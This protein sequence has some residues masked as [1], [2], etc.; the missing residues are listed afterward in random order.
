M[1][2]CGRGPCATSLLTASRSRSDAALAMA[3]RS[4][5]A[6][7]LA[8]PTA[9]GVREA[10][11]TAQQAAGP[12]HERTKR[13]YASLVTVMLSNEMLRTVFDGK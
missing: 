1:R 8:S 12:R 2:A 5:Q 7:G 3:E 4:K 11:F 9:D 13:V 6:Q 10:L